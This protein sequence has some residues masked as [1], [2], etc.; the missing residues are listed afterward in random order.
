MKSK[1]EELTV[2]ESFKNAAMDSPQTCTPSNQ[3]YYS[4][5]PTYPTPCP[6]CGRCPY[7][8]HGGSYPHIS[9][10]QPYTNTCSSGLG[11]QVSSG[12]LQNGSINS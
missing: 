7:C 3:N 4:P 9:W 11:I 8:G 12:G 1:K 2:M 5:Y 6:A 10:T